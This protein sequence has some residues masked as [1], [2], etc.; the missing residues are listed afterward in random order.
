MRNLFKGMTILRDGRYTEQFL[1][2]LYWLAG[3]RRRQLALYRL[4]Q[5]MTAKQLAFQTRMRTADCSDILCDLATVGLVT[6]L[7]SRA[8]RSRVYWLTQRGRNCQAALRA[9]LGLP[10]IKPNFPNVDWRIYGWVCFSHRAAIVKA[11]SEPLCPADIKRR[12]T[13]RNP[14]L[15]MSANNVRD[16]IRKLTRYGVVRSVFVGKRKHPLYALTQ[17][18]EGCRVLLK[19][20]DDRLW[21]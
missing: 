17:L 6:C 8:N 20:M 9:K 11:L 19:R 4:F 15:R 3:S 18:G 10:A 1:Q 2:A 13:G 7:N 5:P 21:R 16:A 14:R 12:A